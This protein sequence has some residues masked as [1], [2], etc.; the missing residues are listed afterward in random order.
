MLFNFRLS[1]TLSR[2][3]RYATHI[4]L[5]AVPSPRKM[6]ARMHGHTRVLSRLARVPKD[7]RCARTQ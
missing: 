7:A 4:F 2:A 6:L 1:M 3:L 5:S